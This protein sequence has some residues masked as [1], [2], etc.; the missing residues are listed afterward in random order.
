LVVARYAPVS[1]ASAA[2]LTIG[3]KTS[4]NV[5]NFDSARNFSS[6]HDDFQ[7]K[8]KVVEGEDEALKLIQ[9]HV[10]S[11]PI[12]LYMKGNPS[13]PMCKKRYKSVIG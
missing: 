8:R 3:N 6:S 5:N 7:P 13:M 11:N 2:S 10:D 12:M 1:S 9:Q 4:F